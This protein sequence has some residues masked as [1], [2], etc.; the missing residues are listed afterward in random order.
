MLTKGNHEDELRKIAK[1]LKFS[2]DH[3]IPIVSNIVRSKAMDD[4][5]ELQNEII[6]ETIHERFSAF[7]KN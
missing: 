3:N 7:M 1:R 6:T 2:Y 5:N 4:L